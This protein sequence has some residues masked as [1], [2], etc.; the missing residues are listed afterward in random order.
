MD[1]TDHQIQSLSIMLSEAGLHVADIGP[2]EHGA[3]APILIGFLPG[4]TNPVIQ[5]NVRQI[6]RDIDQMFG[7][8]NLKTD[9]QLT[10]A[11]ESYLNE[12]LPIA[13]EIIST[14]GTETS[15]KP[16]PENVHDSS[17]NISLRKIYTQLKQDNINNPP[18]FYENIKSYFLLRLNDIYARIN[19]IGITNQYC[20][21]CNDILESKT[22]DNQAKIDFISA[23]RNLLKN[24]PD[25]K[26]L[27]DDV[28]RLEKILFVLKYIH[29]NNSY[30]VCINAHEEDV[31]RQVWMRIH[32]SRNNANKEILLDMFESELL[33]LCNSTKD[34]RIECVNGRIGAIIASLEIYDFANLAQIKS[35]PAIRMMIVQNSAPKLIDTF[36][37]NYDKEVVMAYVRGQ[38]SPFVEQMIVDLR[39][40]I[41]EQIFAEYKDIIT[42]YHI[43]K[44]LNEIFSEL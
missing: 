9:E 26:K 38:T 11:I 28:N 20:S 25:V 3:I 30:A 44:I 19:S 27:I 14:R 8:E 31:L 10:F 22:I 1:L 32:D 2:D 12:L 24:L 5:Y 7:G 43:E 29:T 39:T 34:E 35:V 37:S 41:R 18:V 6:L 33:T 36:L 23:F 42:D 4:H 40:Y 16:D 17:V 15:W 13:N 21:I